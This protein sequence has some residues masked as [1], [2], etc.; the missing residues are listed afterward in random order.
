MFKDVTIELSYKYGY[1]P[2]QQKIS[3]YNI[4]RQ[5]KLLTDEWAEVVV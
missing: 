4:L 2:D 3:T 5:A 1:P